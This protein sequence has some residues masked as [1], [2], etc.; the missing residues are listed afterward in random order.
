MTSY[1]SQQ[2]ISKRHFFGYPQEDNSE[3]FKLLDYASGPGT[4]SAALAPF[5]T[6]TLALDLSTN[7]IAEY[8]FRFPNR[9]SHNA[10]TGN[11]LAI[12]PWVGNQ[13]QALTEEEIAKNELYNGYDALLIGLGFHHFDKWAEALEKLSHRV[14]NGGVIGIVDLIPDLDVNLPSL[15]P[16]IYYIEIFN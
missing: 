14:K 5:T 12:H 9:S 2:L 7:M 1:I 8:S 16:T 10:V 13:E 11:L 4:I 3:H 6:E 15:I